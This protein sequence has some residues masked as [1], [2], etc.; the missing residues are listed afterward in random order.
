MERSVRNIHLKWS[1]FLGAWTIVLVVLSI[2]VLSMRQRREYEVRFEEIRKPRAVAGA[3]PSVNVQALELV[4]QSQQ[5]SDFIQSGPPPEQKQQAEVL[6]ATTKRQA[7]VAS[8]KQNLQN[9]G[10]VWSG[11]PAQTGQFPYQVGLVFNNFVPYASRGL[12]CGGVLIDPRW[13]LTAG[14]CFESDS[15]TTDFQVFDGH[16]KLSESGPDCNCFVQVANLYRHPNYQ[17]IDTQY[18]QIIDADVALLQLARPLTLSTLKIAQPDS[19]PA[20]L[21][22]RLGTIVGWGKSTGNPNSLSDALL[23]GTVRIAA[24]SSCTSAFSTGVI[25]PDMV[26]ATPYP[27]SACNGD[28]GGPLIGFVE[29]GDGVTKTEYVEGIVSWGYPLGA[30]PPSKPT[31]FSRLP[32]KPLSDWVNQCISGQSCPSSL[33]KQ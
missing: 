17:L 2:L 33:T 13:V 16:L 8:S 29:K 25:R 30:C 18:G 31:I 24:D 12:I 7:A 15:Q 19:E 5:V 1:A 23:Y 9:L 21:K 20:I 32:A 11:G 14:H 22:A 4:L 26:C 27:A 10:F 28:S 3:P 6:L